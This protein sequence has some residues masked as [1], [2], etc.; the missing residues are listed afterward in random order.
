MKK[1]LSNILCTLLFCWF[2]W[3]LVSMIDTNIHNTS[4]YN[5]ANW[6]MFAIVKEV[7]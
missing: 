5:Y 3:F 4:D 2:V 1:V 7:R 6:N